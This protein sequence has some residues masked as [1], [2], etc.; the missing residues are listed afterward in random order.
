MN[1]LIILLLVLAFL[2]I[3]FMVFFRLYWQGK[4]SKVDQKF[5]RDNLKKIL[6]EKDYSRQ[7]L[8]LDKLLDQMLKRKGLNGSLGEKLKNNS[9]LFSNL[10]D[11][12][13]AH[14]L[15]NKIAHELDYRISSAQGSKAVSIFKKAFDD[16]GLNAK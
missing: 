10:D 3:M 16:L 2:Y 6:D 13:F 7:I 11:L 1:W 8:E 15:R 14:K 5:F 4:W 12:W 9:Y